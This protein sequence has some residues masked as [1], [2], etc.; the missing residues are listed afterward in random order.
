MNLGRVLYGAMGTEWN[1]TILSGA[2][3]SY[4]G[5]V[6]GP[7][8]W[9]QSFFADAQHLGPFPV[10]KKHGDLNYELELPQSL[11]AHQVFHVDC[12]SPWKGNNVNG[13]N[14]PLP[15][16]MEIDEEEE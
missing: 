5:Y 3:G 4:S 11:K 14:P 7:E 15:E 16:P 8:L 9:P 2:M 13:V 10:I 6:I 1:G 12:L